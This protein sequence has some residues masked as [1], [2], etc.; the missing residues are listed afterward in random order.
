VLRPWLGGSLA[1]SG[2]FYLGMR[3]TARPPLPKATASGRP[4]RAAMLFAFV[5]IRLYLERLGRCQVHIGN[6]AQVNMAQQSLLLVEADAHGARRGYGRAPARVLL[7]ASSFQC[8]GTKI[9]KAEPPGRCH[10]PQLLLLTQEVHLYS[11][12]L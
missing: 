2:L 11:A 10:R 7:V 4:G 5:F 1:L 12:F 6:K 9:I 3:D 8:A